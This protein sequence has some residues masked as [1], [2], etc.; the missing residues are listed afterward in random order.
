M[1][2][3]DLKGADLKGVDQ[4]PGLGSQ[5]STLVPHLADLLTSGSAAT[6]H[7][8]AD[9]TPYVMMHRRADSVSGPQRL[10]V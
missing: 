3:V 1:K 10:P 8:V 2:G 5:R 9:Q 6:F 7:S 4:Q